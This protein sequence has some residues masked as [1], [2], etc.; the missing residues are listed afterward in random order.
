MMKISALYF[1]SVVVANLGFTYLPMINLPG[2]QS[3]APM[4]FLVGLI[5]ILRDFAQ[6][7]LGHKVL[8]FMGLGVVV[9]YLLADP[10]VA[11]ASA[12]AF[13]LSELID[14]LVYTFT[15]KPMKERILISSAISTPIDSSVFMLMLSFFSLPGLIIMTASKMF[16]AIAIYIWLAKK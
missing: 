4:S 16:A 5:F 12:V 3:L 15:K 10:Y 1:G 11:L 13:A 8:F 14:W 2:G 6:R 9:S 7:E